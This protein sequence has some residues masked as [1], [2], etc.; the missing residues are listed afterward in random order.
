MYKANVFCFFEDG[1][2]QGEGY[3]S[4]GTPARGAEVR[5]YSVADN[6]LI[7]ETRTDDLGQFRVSVEISGTLKIVMNAGQGHRAEF[8]MTQEP[9]APKSRPSKKHRAGLSG[10]SV[11]IGLGMTAGIFTIIWL[12]KRNHAF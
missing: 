5:I 10:V 12:I 9:A 6:A 8:M 4:G 2:I 3:Y 7:A 1:M 11:L